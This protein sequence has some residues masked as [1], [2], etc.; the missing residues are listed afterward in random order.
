V[1]WGR[2]ARSIRATTDT[3]I[4][5]IVERI[6]VLRTG[7]KSESPNREKW[8][9]RCLIGSRWSLRKRESTSPR[10]L[11][12]SEAGANPRSPEAPWSAA[13][14]GSSTGSVL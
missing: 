7:P 14:V 12:S 4:L 9:C 13:R 2:T 1:C 6:T 8:A 5:I 10:S 11:V 3:T